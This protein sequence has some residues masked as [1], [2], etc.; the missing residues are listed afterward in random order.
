MKTLL[1]GLLALTSIS[2][3]AND[4]LIRTSGIEINYASCSDKEVEK[5]LDTSN[6]KEAFNV[7]LSHNYTLKDTWIQQS[8][9]QNFT[10]YHLELKP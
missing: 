2:A 1:I 7:A 8:D 3:I 6:I 9:G 10:V 4:C 5:E